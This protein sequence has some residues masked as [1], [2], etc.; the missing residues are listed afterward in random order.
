MTFNCQLL[1]QLSFTWGISV[2]F[3]SLSA[4]T[5][6][7]PMNNKDVFVRYRYLIP[8]FSANNCQFRLSM[9]HANSGLQN[10]LPCLK[11]SLTITSS[12]RPNF[13]FIPWFNNV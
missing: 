8:R 3:H 11:L 13:P 1:M 5:G 9:K 12:V 10:G 4:L 6:M 7:S 2:S